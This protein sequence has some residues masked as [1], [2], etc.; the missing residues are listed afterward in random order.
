[1]P[2]PNEMPMPS[3]PSYPVFQTF[4]KCPRVNKYDALP[5]LRHRPPGK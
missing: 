1:V 2:D 4:L 5:Q 3:L